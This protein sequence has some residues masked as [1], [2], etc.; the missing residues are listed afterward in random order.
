MDIDIGGPV[1]A[2]PPPQTAPR[3]RSRAT[4][5]VLVAS[6]LSATVAS[7]VTAGT[8][9]VLREPLA[10]ATPTASAPSATETVVRASLPVGTAADPIVAVAAAVSPAVVT[11][12]SSGISD[13]GPFSVPATG[14]GSGFVFRSDGL[15]L[16]NWHVVDGAAELTVALNDGRTLPGRVTD[17][18][19]AHDL[20]VVTVE[21]TGLAS[22]ELGS[23]AGL[24]PGQAVVA[25]GSPLGTFTDSVTSGILSAL[26]RSID[27]SGASGRRH[28]TDLLQTD[29]AINEG[30]SGGPLL[31]LSGRVIGV[32]V[33]VA[34]SA[35]GIGFAIPIDAARALIARAPG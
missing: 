3:P 7:L 26:G 2:P 10:T 8:V 16:T 1:A 11:I 24:V 32:N 20:A 14:V 4:G 21:A 13:Y 29:A 22:A 30:N 6:I 35:E 28:L 23:S 33:A 19:P 25:I 34:I 17:S 9:V 27:V 31:D 15:I 5:L 18:D 12:T